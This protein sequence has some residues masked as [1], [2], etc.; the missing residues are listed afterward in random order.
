MLRMI[1]ASLM[2]GVLLYMTIVFLPE[3]V[4]I[5]YTITKWI[6]VIIACLH[7]V[8]SKNN[9]WVNFISLFL[10]FLLFLTII[11]VTVP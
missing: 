6:F 8:F 1:T 7:F 3:V 2:F 11:T 9:R 10:A 4:R 5:P